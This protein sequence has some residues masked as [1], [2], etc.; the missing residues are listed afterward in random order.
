MFKKESSLLIFLL[1]LILTLFVS[2][3]VFD[4]QSKKSIFTRIEILQ[5]EITALKN[6]PPSTKIISPSTSSQDIV[7]VVKKVQPSVVSIIASKELTRYR[8]RN[9]FFF[10]DPFFDNFFG[11]PQ[12][13]EEP[14]IQQ[15]ETEKVKVGGGSGFIYSQNGYIIA[16]KH[17]IQDDSAEYT[18]VL[19]DGTEFLA[20]VI[21][22]DPFN[23]IAIIKIDPKETIL[24]PV[25]LGDS[26]K[27]EVGEKVVAIGNAL[28]E[29]QNTVTTGIV[30]AI[31]RKIV[32]GNQFNQEEIQN[33]IQTDAAINP[34]NSGGPLVNIRGEVIGMNTAIADGANGIGFALPINDIRFI[35]KN[36]ETHGKYIRPYIGIKYIMLNEKIAE[37]YELTQKEGAYIIGSEKERAV[38]KG[39]PA[40]LAGILEEDIIIKIDGQEI[41]K[42]YDVIRAIAEKIAGEEILITVLRNNTEKEIPLTLGEYPQ[43]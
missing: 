37:E 22:K 15:N 23:D 20:E 39:S 6:T 31:G 35:A 26:S 3:A 36:V 13:F 9:P 38:L 1:F 32:A 40:D 18:V 33:L 14:Q 30:S 34:G 2:Y 7:S 4:M 28:A 41:N 24:V 19:H 16:N 43:Q 17:V 10:S 5:E 42:D 25:S 8:Q 12:Q 29:F 11:F 27:I 21:A